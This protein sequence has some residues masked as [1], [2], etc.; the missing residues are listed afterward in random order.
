MPFF[1]RK[2]MELRKSRNLRQEDLARLLNVSRATI[3]YYESKAKNPTT[4]FVQKIS[5]FFHISI[6]ELLLDI[7][8]KD[9]K[10]GPKSQIQKHI[11]LV[12]QLPKEE[13]RVVFTLIDSLAKK[14]A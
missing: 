6:D 14:H 9:V 4:E 5:E 7:E 11:E 12:K 1:G 2:L 13:Q 8:D 10:P 3:S